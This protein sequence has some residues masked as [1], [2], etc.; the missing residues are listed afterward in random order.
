VIFRR[1][2]IKSNGQPRAWLKRLLFT[3]NFEVKP[4]WRWA[5]CLPGGQVR[6][7]FAPWYAQAQ[8][9]P[10][11]ELDP[12]WAEIRSNLI[13]QKSLS[14]CR[15]VHIIAPPA[16][17]YVA[18]MLAHWLT[19][20]GMSCHV[21]QDMPEAFEEALYIVV[22]PQVYRRLPPRHLRIVYQME[23]S[24]SPRW[25]TD[26]YFNVLYNALAVFDYSQ[27][28][29]SFLNQQMAGAT[30]LVHVPVEP[31]PAGALLPIAHDHPPAEPGDCEV[32]FYG[33]EKSPRRQKFLADL[34]QHFRMK[35][36]NGLYGPAL[37]AELQKAKV[38]VNIHYYEQ[39]L[40][41]TTRISECLSL[42]LQV[43]SEAGS[44]QAMHG[45]W[46]KAVTF[47]PIDD[48]AAMRAAVAA[49]LAQ[50]QRRICEGADL[51]LPSGEALR[52]ALV[53]LGL[54]LG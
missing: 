51:G 12:G 36:I 41:E 40:L 6:P 5:A 25:F 31:L 37:W 18:R 44:D 46:S 50:P 27:R 15:S 13:A 53:T 8:A 21:G 43:V 7:L 48:V 38:V 32:V 23:Q 29:L 35:L 39:A 45:Q 33:D 20:W 16:T 3:R 19:G 49:A 28:N 34:K 11:P 42:G 9:N 47:T 30:P 2:F 22:C 10:S 26:E 4:T 24:V 52:A 54:P 14:A 1:V 17:G